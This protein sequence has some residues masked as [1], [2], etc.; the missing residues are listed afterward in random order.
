LVPKIPLL[1]ERPPLKV[2]K[3]TPLFPAVAKVFSIGDQATS[4]TGSGPPY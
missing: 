4:K 1:D 2:Q 3:V